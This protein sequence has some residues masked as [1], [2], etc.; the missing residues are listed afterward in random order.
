M[1]AAGE[2]STIL[3]SDLGSVNNIS[4]KG[5]QCN[6]L[7]QRPRGRSKKSVRALKARNTLQ[8]SN[9]SISLLQSL[10]LSSLTDPGALPQAITSR[11]FGAFSNCTHSGILKLVDV[12]QRR[13][14]LNARSPPKERWPL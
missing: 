9:R 5:A 10:V 3:V 13:Q 1:K 2:G 4:A 12:W 6:S 7:G 11:D 8:I 14:S